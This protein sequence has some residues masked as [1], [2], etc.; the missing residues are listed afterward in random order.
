M[1]ESTI[2][3]SDETIKFE[4]PHQDHFRS[5]H[6]VDDRELLNSSLFSKTDQI[7]PNLDKKKKINAASAINPSSPQTNE[8]IRQ[9]KPQIKFNFLLPNLSKSN[10]T[11]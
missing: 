4:I 1:N 2:E 10:T 11:Q 9:M 3:K 6:S 5:H 8:D 7:L